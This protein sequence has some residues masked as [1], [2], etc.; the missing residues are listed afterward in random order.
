MI[1]GKDSK[2][3]PVLA[4][5]RSAAF[6]DIQLSNY[7]PKTRPTLDHRSLSGVL[8]CCLS[9]ALGSKATGIKSVA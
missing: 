5:G 1:M 6:L 3:G 8:F 4:G 7:V 9:N 2:P